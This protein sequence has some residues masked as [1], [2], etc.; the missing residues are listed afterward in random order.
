MGREIRRVPPNWQHP[1]EIHSY[2]GVPVLR[3]MFSQTLAEAQAEW[4]RERDELETG[5]LA[6]KAQ[7]KYE[8]YDTYE[9]YAGERPSDPTYYTP[10]TK[11]EATWYQVWQTVSEGTPVTPPFA[12]LQELEDHLVQYGENLKSGFP[13]DER[14]P[15][16][17]YSRQAAAQ[18]CK[19]QWA[20]SLII[21][22]GQFYTARTG[23]PE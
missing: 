9:D 4:D 21:S 19:N 18:F 11:E 17:R 8:D 7:G 1:T 15:V 3:V 10:Y 6:K 2:W 22:G 23:F 13:S 20:P 14:Y 12:T 5:F 16:E